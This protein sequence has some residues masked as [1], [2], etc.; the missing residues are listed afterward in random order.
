MQNFFEEKFETF[1]HAAVAIFKEDE[2][3]TFFTK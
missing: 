1:I 2:A 3:T